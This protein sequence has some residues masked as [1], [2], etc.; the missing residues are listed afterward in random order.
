VFKRRVDV[1]QAFDVLKYPANEPR[2]F[3]FNVPA[4][5]AAWKT[6]NGKWTETGGQFVPT[7]TTAHPFST[8]VTTNCNTDYDAE[9][10]F[11]FDKATPDYF[12]FAIMPKSQY[13]VNSAGCHLFSGYEV[14][15]NFYP[16][17][18]IPSQYYDAWVD[19]F[20]QYSADCGATSGKILGRTAVLSTPKLSKL[21]VEV[22]GAQIM[23]FVQDKKVLTVKDAT[24]T[25][26]SLSMLVAS[27][28]PGRKA[29]VDKFT[30]T[31][32]DAKTPEREHSH[33][34]MNEGDR[35]PPL[36]LPWLTSSS[37]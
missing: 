31:P 10:V 26:G 19:R 2:V 22:R 30:I 33:L 27:A 7:F 37:L 4:D 32:E 34:A 20:D 21:K 13:T 17:N 23:V 36:A 12:H 14:I 8:A 24:Y 35:T 15:L 18:T 11:S 25:T 29:G 5:A 28:K 6:V 3:D 16:D 9:M 1:A